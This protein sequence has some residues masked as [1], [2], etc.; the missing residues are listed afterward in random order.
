MTTIIAILFTQVFISCLSI[1]LTGH[2]TP[3]E[4]YKSKVGLAIDSK[5]Y[6][7]IFLVNALILGIRKLINCPSCT[8]FWITLIINGLSIYTFKVAI[9]TYIFTHLLNQKINTVNL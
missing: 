1:I 8:S 3:L 5:M 9:I 4:Y 6:S 7:E 2:I